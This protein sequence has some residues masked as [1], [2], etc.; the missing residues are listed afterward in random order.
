MR[1]G[2]M[3]EQQYRRVRGRFGVACETGM[4]LHEPVTSRESRQIELAREADFALGAL[5]I[6]PA[7][8]EVVAGGV[9][10]VIEPR[11]MQVLVA[12][13]RRKDEVVSRN[14]LVEAC[15]A[16]RVVGEDAISRCIARLRRLGET[17]GGFSLATIARVGYR[18]TERARA[19]DAEPSLGSSIDR[20]RRRPLWF[21]AV[22]LLLMAG[23]GFALRQW[24]LATAA[25]TEQAIV[26]DE[27]VISRGS[28][29]RFG[30]TAMAK[31]SCMRDR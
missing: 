26:Q 23:I 10:E 6:R 21:V 14:D 8:R 22:A 11:V 13:A 5:R 7:L 18:L 9:V 19:P 17:H 31:P 12:L 30:T 27:A 16:G 20:P 3:G 2:C 28:P 24:H 4:H 25:R 29:R 1:E 15:W